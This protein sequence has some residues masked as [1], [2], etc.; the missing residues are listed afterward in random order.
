MKD[1]DI[2][3]EAMNIP[4]ATTLDELKFL[5]NM[6]KKVGPEPESRQNRFVELGTFMGRSLAVIAHYAKQF[7]GYV[8]SFDD[9]QSNQKANLTKVRENMERLGLRDNVLTLSIDTKIRPKTMI[10]IDFLF[11]DTTHTK[12]HFDIEMSQW[13][14]V[15]RRDGIIVCHDYNSPRWVEMTGAIDS[16]FRNKNFKFL[17]Q[18][19]RM[20]AFQKLTDTEE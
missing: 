8:Y 14:P 12:E 9:Y 3:S 2:F 18:E 16:W 19:R 7:N 4:G 15:V 20:I 13:L 1:I 6:V 10:N 17:G 5:S 11:V